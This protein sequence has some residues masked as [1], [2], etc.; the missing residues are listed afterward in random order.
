MSARQRGAWLARPATAGPR[1]AALHPAPRS[2]PPT[3]PLRPDGARGVHSDAEPRVPIVPPRLSERASRRTIL[4]T[5]ARAASAGRSSRASAARGPGVRRPR[6][7]PAPCALRTGGHSVGSRLRRR[8]RPLL[9]ARSLFIYFF[10]VRNDAGYLFIYLFFPH[11]K[12]ATMPNRGT[13]RRGPMISVSVT[14][15][16]V[17]DHWSSCPVDGRQSDFVPLGAGAVRGADSAPWG[18]APC[19]AG[20]R[21]ASLC[22]SHSMPAT[23]SLPGVANQRCPQTSAGS[24]V[25]RLGL[26]L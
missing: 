19:T 13:G 18:A 12:T 23:P 16:G 24:R 20:C 17:F 21:A 26:A 7:R 22:C 10:D 6:G 15:F 5:R 9:P 1:H 4:R 3:T 8:G 2:R 14:F 11:R 25:A